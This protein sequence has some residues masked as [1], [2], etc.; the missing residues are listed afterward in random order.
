M[1]HWSHHLFHINWLIYCI[2]T[3]VLYV[4][5]PHILLL[6]LQ[7]IYR[8]YTKQDDS[9]KSASDFYLR[10]AQ[11][12]SRPGH[13]KSWV[14]VFKFPQFLQTTARTAPYIRPWSLSFISFHIIVHSHHSTLCGKNC[15]AYQITW[16]LRSLTLHTAVVSTVQSL[17]GSGQHGQATLCLFQNIY[18]FGNRST[19]SNCLIY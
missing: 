2:Y 3:S 5:F 15:C 12:I 7:D 19:L 1:L 18:S 9:V 4:I 13:Q 17:L 16:Y 11:F 14:R 6:H 8:K 10:G